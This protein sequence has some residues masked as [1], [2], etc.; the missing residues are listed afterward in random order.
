MAPYQPVMAVFVTS[1]LY[2][3]GG[4]WVGKGPVRV[5]VLAF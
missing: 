4:L 2:E 1:I 5:I 3:W